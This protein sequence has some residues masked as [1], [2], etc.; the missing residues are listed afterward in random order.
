MLFGLAFFSGLFTVLSPCIWH[1]LPLILTSN[2]GGNKKYAMGL[3]LGVSAT[4][5][6]FMLFFSYLVKLIPI[7]AS[8]FRNFS[9]IFIFSFGI[10]LLIKPLTD[11]LETVLSKFTSKFNIKVSKEPGFKRGFISGAGMS[12][13]WS[14][15][16]GPILITIST[17]GAMQKVDLFV[18]LF[19]LLYVLGIAIPLFIITLLGAKLTYLTQKISKFTKNTN[20]IT[21]AVFIIT[22]F[23]MYSELGSKIEYYVISKY[24]AYYKYVYFL[25][26]NDRTL[27][28]LNKLRNEK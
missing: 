15:C 22:A 9:I 6:L 14:P 2:I 11:L 26:N 12:F 10:V 27:N 7:E 13:L 8:V 23:L 16:A 4:F 17:I 28:E 18:V 21:G 5:G 20:Q 24:P 3:S 25:E 1:V 19:T